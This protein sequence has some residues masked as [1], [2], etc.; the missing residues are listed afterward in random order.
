M[1]A[2]TGTT[3]QRKRDWDMNVPV[4]W[5]DPESSHGV[6]EQGGFSGAAR[7]PGLSQPTVSRHIEGLERSL[8]R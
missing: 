6:L 8:G 3:K 7:E 1:L 4:N 5:H 2:A